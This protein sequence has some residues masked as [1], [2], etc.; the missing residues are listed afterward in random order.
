MAWNMPMPQQQPQV[1]IADIVSGLSAGQ[2]FGTGIIEGLITNEKYKAAQQANQQAM[3][4]QQA[5]QAYQQAGGGQQGIEAAGAINPATGMGLENR[6][7]KKISSAMDLH[8][9]MKGSTYGDLENYKTQYRPQMIKLGVPPAMLPEVNTTEELNSLLFRNEQMAAQFKQ[10][11]MTPDK[12]FKASSPGVVF[13]TQSQKYIRDPNYVT[14]TPGGLARPYAEGGTQFDTAPVSADQSSRQ[15]IAGMKYK[16]KEEFK[17]D[18]KK[19]NPDKP[20]A[21]MEKD[22]SMAVSAGKV[23][24]KGAAPA[25]AGNDAM[26]SRLTG[27]GGGGGS[28]KLPL[29]GGGYEDVDE[30]T[31]NA[32]IKQYGKP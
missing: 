21:E 11:M 24:G 6:E 15:T 32:Y 1:G 7:I 27:G 28:Y 30:A 18:W 31:Y 4:E 29:K 23:V 20:L 12:R 13:D 9:R 16:D 25:G 5:L 17:A 22:Y 26:R 14:K 2:K 3:A 19:R 8:D 10:K